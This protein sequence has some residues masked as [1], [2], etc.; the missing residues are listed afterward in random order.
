[1]HPLTRRNGGGTANILKNLLIAAFLMWGGVSFAQTVENVNAEFRDQKVYVT[2][3][4]LH[5]DSLQSFYV[6]FYSSH[7]NY[8]TPIPVTEAMRIVLPGR[9]RRAELELKN[10]F[11]SGYEGDVTIKVKASVKP[12]G[13][14]QQPT[15]VATSTDVPKLK[16]TA[17]D[18]ASYKRGK[19]MS[20]RWSEN[21]PVKVE[22]MQNGVVQLQLAQ[23]TS[24]HF[25]WAI[26]RDTKTGKDYSIRVSRL[27]NSCQVE[28]FFVDLVCTVEV[29]P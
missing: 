11:P 4:L 15:A 21:A 6:S 28:S 16:L 20:L 3:D 13:P 10:L 29:K 27:T 22:L 1:M 14:V 25:E 12:A 24:N 7:N 5:N 18:N 8:T 23:V 19:T 9:G 2:Y 26:P 17:L